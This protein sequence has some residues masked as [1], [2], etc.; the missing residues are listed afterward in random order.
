MFHRGEKISEK[1]FVRVVV[2]VAV[3]DVVHRRQ[4]KHYDSE[5]YAKVFAEKGCCLLLL[6]LPQHRHQ[7]H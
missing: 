2:V 6:E 3:D 5:G 7:Q 1:F 4:M